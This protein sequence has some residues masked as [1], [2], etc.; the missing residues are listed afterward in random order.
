MVGA[1]EFVCRRVLAHHTLVRFSVARVAFIR[2]DRLGQLG[3]TPVRHA[4]HQRRDGRSQ[5]ATAIGVVGVTE[6]HQ[7]RAEIGVSDAQLTE[8]PRGVRD[9]LGREVRE[10]DGNVHRRDHELDR[11]CEQLRVKRIIG[12]QEFEQIE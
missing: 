9:R 10:A 3:G 4:G 6:R 5:G 2:A 8:L 11:A 7:Q 12:C 1:D